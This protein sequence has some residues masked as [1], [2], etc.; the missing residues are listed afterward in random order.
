MR[1]MFPTKILQNFTQL[2]FIVSTF[3]QI[4]CFSLNLF[5]SNTA[6]R[7]F[8]SKAMREMNPQFTSDED[9]EMKT[10]PIYLSS[11]ESEIAS[12]CK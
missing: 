3:N 1:E 5:S 4:N 6:L 2:S 9:Q 11:D 7:Q 12:P 8:K 10:Q